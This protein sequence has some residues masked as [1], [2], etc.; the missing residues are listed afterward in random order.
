MAFPLL[1]LV[2]LKGVGASSAF[3]L[4]LVQL[5]AYLCEPGYFMCCPARA[6]PDGKAQPWLGSV[7]TA[8]N[9]TS[10]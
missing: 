6:V 9:S 4:V 7:T 8:E 10:T 3:G 5:N 1:T 2:P